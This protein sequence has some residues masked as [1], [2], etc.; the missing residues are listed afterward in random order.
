MGIDGESEDA[1]EINVP[2]ADRANALERIAA[3]ARRGALGFAIDRALQ[4]RRVQAK[5]ALG[6]VLALFHARHHRELEIRFEEVQ[7]LVTRDRERVIAAMHQ[8]SS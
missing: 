4:A 2:V 5:V 1:A 8:A 7:D 3:I 6:I